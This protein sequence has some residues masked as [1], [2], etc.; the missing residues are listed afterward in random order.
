LGNTAL[1]MGDLSAARTYYDESNAARQTIGD[2]GR[3]LSRGLAHLALRTGDYASAITHFQNSLR[4]SWQAQEHSNVLECLRGLAMAYGT[5]QEAQ[6]AARLL[7]ATDA[8]SVQLN[9]HPDTEQRHQHETTLAKLRDIL[10]EHGLAQTY[11]DGRALTMA[12][13]VVV[14]G[15]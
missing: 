15:I 5:A 1:Q 8:F 12:Q 13:A 7:G 6:R 9:L 2:D 4:I 10:G 3:Y 14:A 11:A